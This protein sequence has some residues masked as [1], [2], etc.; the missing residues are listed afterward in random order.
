VHQL[1]TNGIPSPTSHLDVAGNLVKR[2]RLRGGDQ[3]LPQELL[4]RGAITQTTVGSRGLFM[5]IHRVPPGAHSSLHL[6]RNCETAVYVLRGRAYSYTGASLEEYF[7]A[8]A[9]DFVYIP[10]DAPHVV[11]NPSPDEV[12]EYVV[13]RN[14][15]D[16]V[17]VTLRDA[18]DL[19]IGPD[20]RMRAA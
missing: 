18:A 14:A 19:P 20:G 4:G 13:C 7:E 2:V 17:V 5:A 10:A 3:V 6:H 11:G 9:G 8:R 1:T 16:E 15:P 12:L